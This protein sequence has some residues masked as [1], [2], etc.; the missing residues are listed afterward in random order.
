MDVKDLYMEIE[1]T[2]DRL[3]DIRK[4]LYVNKEHR[5]H[6]NDSTAFEEFNDELF[7]IQSDLRNLVEYELELFFD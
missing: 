6:M 2:A 1:E 7:K 5:E 4:A 3:E